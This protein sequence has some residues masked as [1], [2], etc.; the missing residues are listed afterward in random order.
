MNNTIKAILWVILGVFA[1]SICSVLIGQGA[2]IVADIG[3]HIQRL[4]KIGDIRP[5]HKGFSAFV[6]LVLIAI[7]IGWAIKRFTKKGR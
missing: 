4:T 2:E 5:S 3:K 7:F 6:E 1:I